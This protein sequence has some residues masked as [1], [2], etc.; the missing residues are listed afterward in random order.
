M[1]VMNRS[2]GFPTSPWG[3]FSRRGSRNHHASIGQA[4]QLG[5]QA[6]EAGQELRGELAA[7]L[8]S[9]T[10]RPDLAEDPGGPRRGDLPAKTAGHQIA[11]HRVQPAGGLVA[12]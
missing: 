1:T 12:G 10:W 2:P 7:G 8:G 3:S 6:A 11:Q 4:K 5:I 9:N